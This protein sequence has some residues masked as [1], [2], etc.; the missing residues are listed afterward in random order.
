MVAAGGWLLI[1]ALVWATGQRFKTAYLDYGWQLIPWDVLS[2][3]PLRSVWYL[4]IQPPFW[5]LA[6]G[7]LAW[8][9]PFSDAITLQALQAAIG[10]AGA[11]CAAAL[12]RR[13]RVGAVG[14]V[15]I[16]L[17][18][19]ANP[20][21]LRNAFE[22]TYELAVSTL[23]LGLVLALTRFAGEPAWRRGPVVIAAVATTVVLTRSLYHPVWLVVIVGATL[24]LARRHLDRRQ[25]VAAIAVPLVLIGGWMVKNQ[26]L[27]GRPT[28]SSWVGMNLQRAVIPVLDAD[29][30]QRMYDA[31]EVSDIALV[32]PFGAYDLYAPYMAPCTPTHHHRSVD[33]PTRTT[34]PV[35]PNFNDE[36][37]L[38][39]FDQAGDDA[40]AVI[41]A[42]PGVYLEGRMWSA[43]V[44]F[45]VS[46]LPS[47]SPSVAMRLLDDVYSIAR[48]DYRGEISTTAWG[49]PIY[50]SLAAPTDFGIAQILLYTGVGIAGVWQ[51]VRFRRHA[52][53]QWA[54]ACVATLLVAGWTFVVGVA[55]ELGEQARFRT[56]TDPLVWVVGLCG[57]VR[58][59]QCWRASLVEA[60]HD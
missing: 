13:C 17:V 34:D 42:H 51:L 19:T 25:V 59:W 2:H 16:G 39:I 54:A 38:P 37:Y 41:T 50:G 22:P 49:T 5:N 14:A 21:V 3:D 47:E 18:A 26:A 44:M 52:D 15:V 11:A 43:R 10:A 28:L 60:A 36:C 20:E 9:S 46:T 35:S 57:L 8:S 12:A 29:E 7:G 27:Y 48:L 40:W 32:G 31:G 30:L 56:M 23:L 24:V 4:H 45:A 58:L 1:Y 55:G 6:L 33:T 53:D